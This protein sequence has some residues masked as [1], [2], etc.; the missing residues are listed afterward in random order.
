MHQLLIS[1]CS[2]PFLKSSFSRAKVFPAMPQPGV[3]VPGKMVYL[4][5]KHS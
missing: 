1:F 4:S 2:A 3:P 5:A